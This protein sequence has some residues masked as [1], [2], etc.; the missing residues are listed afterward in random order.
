MRNLVAPHT[1]SHQDVAFQPLRGL[2]DELREHGIRIRLLFGRGVG[3]DAALD[4]RVGVPEPA[5][6]ARAR[7]P[8]DPG[9]VNP[10]RPGVRRVVRCRG[11]GEH[12]IERR[13]E[14]KREARPQRFLVLRRERNFNRGGAGGSM[15]QFE[16]RGVAIRI[17]VR[18]GR[19]RTRQDRLVVADAALLIERFEQRHFA[20]AVALRERVRERLQEKVFPPPPDLRQQRHRTRHLGHDVAPRVT[21]SPERTRSAWNTG[22]DRTAAPLRSPKA[23]D[24]ARRARR[25]HRA[26]NLEKIRPTPMRWTA[27]IYSSPITAGRGTTTGARNGSAGTWPPQ[28]SSSTEVSSTIWCDSAEAITSAM[29]R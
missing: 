20:V 8:D 26:S 6:H 4:L 22:P 23:A 27:P 9:R 18:R 11:E 29:T 12:D 21:F 24:L 3:G 7:R 10:E 25:R 28:T 15:D 2:V 1:R 17:V 14:R 19:A 5:H 13:R 16:Q